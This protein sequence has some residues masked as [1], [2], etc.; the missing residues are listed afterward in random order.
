MTVLEARKRILVA[1][2]G[3]HRAI[4]VRDWGEMTSATRVL[5]TE[6]TRVAALAAPV[7]L[8]LGAGC[9]FFRRR[10]SPV[11]SRQ[12]WLRTSLGWVWRT[13]PLGLEIFRASRQA[14]PSRCANPQ[15]SDHIFRQE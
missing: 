5:A 2:S 3:L 8:L 1:E 11:P 14:D 4:L 15:E 6:G 12:S 9:A 10:R 13:L 7:A